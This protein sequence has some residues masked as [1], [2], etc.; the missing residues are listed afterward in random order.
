ML[1][2]IVF[3]FKNCFI[4]QENL[5]AEGQEFAKKYEI[6]SCSEQ[7]NV[8]NRLLFSFLHEVPIRSNT[9]FGK[10][11][12]PIRT[13]NWDVKTYRNKLEQRYY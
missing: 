6:S 3:W 13:N 11:T 2:Y 7:C 8:R 5:R 1:N 10:M 4:D 9:Y 12:M